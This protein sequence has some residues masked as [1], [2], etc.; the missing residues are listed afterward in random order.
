M[1]KLLK[2]LSKDSENRDQFIKTKTFQTMTPKLKF[3]TLRM[4]AW[5]K[6]WMMN[7]Y[8]FL[9]LTLMSLIL[10]VSYEIYL[11]CIYR[12]KGGGK[13]SLHHVFC[14]KLSYLKRNRTIL[15]KLY[16]T[17]LLNICILVVVNF[18]FVYM[19]KS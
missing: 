16:F 11:T 1:K 5:A 6:Y 7:S 8:H 15:Y 19:N 12:G 4:T 17:F 3:P 13:V 2:T 18:Y 14:S 9:C 10:F